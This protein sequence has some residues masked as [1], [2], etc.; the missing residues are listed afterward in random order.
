MAFLKRLW[1]SL[2]AQPKWVI[3]AAVVAGLGA[4]FIFL[5]AQATAESNARKS[6]DAL[7][8][9][10]DADQWLR[11][12][13]S[14]AQFGAD[15]DA[16]K[17]TAVALVNGAPGVALFTTKDGKRSSVTVPG[18]SML[19]CTGTVLDK[20][21]ER[22]DK[23]KFALV[24]VDVD[25][26]TPARRTLDLIGALVSLLA[27]ILILLGALVLLGR[28]MQGDKGSTASK[29]AKRP[30]ISFKDV[31]GNDE[32]KAALS[33][34]K[35]FMHDPKE[36]AAIGAKAPRGVLM[37]GPPGTGKTLLAK[38]LA[39]ESGASFIAVDGSYFTSMFY[40]AGVNKVRDL[41]ELARNNAPCVLFIDEVDGI[42]RR[43]QGG[44]ARGGES[45]ANRIIN[46]LLVEMDGFNVL[47]NV[48][49]VAATNHEGNL[50]EAMRRPGRFDMLVRMKLPTLPERQKLFEMYVAKVSNDG[51][52]DNAVLARMTAGMSPADIANT[53]NK[54]ASTAAE[55]QAKQVSSEHLLRAIETHQLGGEVS[56][57]KDLL[58]EETRRCLAYHEAGHA[59]VG[60]HLKAGVVER[61]TIEPR[62]MALGVT[63]I[64]R[65]TEDPIYKQAELTSRLAMM[66]AGRE[67]E[68][69]AL[70]CVST[71]ASDDLKR[72]SELAINMVGSLGFSKAFGLLSVAG[73]PKE[74]MGPHIQVAVMDEARAMLEHAQAACR[75]VLT[76]RR[77]QLDALAAEL[78]DVEVL[79]GERLKSLLAEPA[80]ALVSL[81]KAVAMQASEF[82]GLPR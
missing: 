27:P 5:G 6:A 50:D 17:V 71:G 70:G 39:G 65:D 53:V 47:D 14:A 64:T 75:T 18:C 23:D 52:T 19:A 25:L 56:S 54:A 43:S 29:L 55:Q 76:E 58:T 37:V 22:G 42:G 77:T 41:F 9:E 49:V 44:E 16:K 59:L 35:A 38:A 12:P 21:A 73:I 69:L 63:Y 7:V 46:R 10:R 34:V 24:R 30:D 81:N 4:A 45:E 51:T 66:L 26:R 8:F 20:L 68:L 61:V 62:G 1:Q 74:L 33:R 79:S 36:Y 15:L 78:L 31:I 67:A 72:A 28:L 82:E 80:G 3:I 11:S 60:H 32:A 57:I 2:R 13:K 40:G 48:V